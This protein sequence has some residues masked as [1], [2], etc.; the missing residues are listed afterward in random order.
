MLYLQWKYNSKIYTFFINSECIC[1]LILIIGLSLEVIR[2]LI[3]SKIEKRKKLAPPSAPPKSGGADIDNAL[4]VLK[5]TSK[6]GAY[7][8]TDGRLKLVLY[9]NFK[10]LI[11][12][13]SP[14]P[15]IIN[16]STFIYLY[17]LSNDKLVKFAFKSINGY[18]ND[19]RKILLQ[20][21]CTTSIVLILSRFLS[22]RAFLSLI[23][24]A[25]TTFSVL[26]SNSR[27]LNCGHLV[28]RLDEIQIERDITNLPK[29]LPYLDIP[30][31]SLRNRIFVVH[32]VTKDNQIYVLD[33][34]KSDIC[35]QQIVYEWDE[36][37]LPIGPMMPWQKQRKKRIIVEQKCESIKSRYKPL[38]A[39]TRSLSD[40]IS[41]DEAS[42][43]IHEDYIQEYERTK[44]NSNKIK[45]D[46]VN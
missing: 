3:R 27:K 46:K 30:Q 34:S 35:Q 5:C 44:E 18:I 42:R 19:A 6:N 9:Q 40:L 31:Q 37:S 7:E 8:L 4:E 25:I 36:N 29:S 26:Y 33:T 16:T 11:G 41:E 21:G 13:N 12:Q 15:I 23:S 45:N 14:L 10:N 22:N 43:K 39:R 32:E 28:R 38:E 17:A 20:G 1:L 24:T 2:R